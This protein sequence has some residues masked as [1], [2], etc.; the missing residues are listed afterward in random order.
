MMKKIIIMFTI[1]IAV[2]LIGI[3]TLFYYFQRLNTVNK[4]NSYLIINS[5]SSL[6]D[7]SKQLQGKSIIKS[8]DT[9][10]LYTKLNRFSNNIKGGNF[11][12]KPNT[13]YKELSL[14]LQSSQSDFTV[15]TIPEGFS[16]YQ[17]AERLEKNTSIKKEDFLGVRVSNLT[18]NSL[19]LN[20]TNIYYGLEGFLYPDTYYVP[21]GATEKE[22]ANLMFDRFNSVFSDKYVDRAKE[23][24]LDINDVITIAS[25]I[26]KEAAND[27]ERSKIAGVIYNRI[28]KGIP[29][30]IDASVIY[31]ITKGESKMKKV[32]YDNLK[33]QDPYNTYVNKGLPPGPI[34][35]PGKPSIEAAL[36][37]EEHDYLYYVVNGSG[38]HVFSK[39][40]EEHLNNVKKYIK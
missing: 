24:G 27:S 30:Q 12:V 9:F 33:V 38:G 35:S 21:N 10:L 31:A 32:L 11:I 16:F 29:L 25:L 19:V 36:Y 39:T 18:T 2:V 13:S 22:I 4:E 1:L 5:E 20:K 26:E 40:Y 15:V 17:I 7:I 6:E 37:P 34:A 8:K 23:L 14:K 28:E 3:G